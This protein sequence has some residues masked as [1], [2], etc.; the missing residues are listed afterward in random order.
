MMTMLQGFRH[1]VIERDEAYYKHFPGVDPLV[2]LDV[3]TGLPVE[4]SEQAE[5]N[6]SE[7]GASKMES[8]AFF[9]L[10]VVQLTAGGLRIIF[11]YLI[12]AHLCQNI[13]YLC[14]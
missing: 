10:T 3:T 2:R 4:E 11:C 9:L 6:Q 8:V 13:R 7:D 12:V 1:Q 14:F 5:I